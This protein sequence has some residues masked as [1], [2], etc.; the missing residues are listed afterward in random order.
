MENGLLF[1]LPELEETPAEKAPEKIIWVSGAEL[2]EYLCVSEP[3]ITK[4]KNTGFL[5]V[6]DKGKY[7]LKECVKSYIAK[8]VRTM[9]KKT[10]KAEEEDLDR[11]EQLWDIE[12]KKT[13]NKGWREQ[14]ATDLIS[15]VLRKL[16][17]STKNFAASLT[18]DSKEASLIMTIM[19]QIQ[20][21]DPKDVFYQKEGLDDSENA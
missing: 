7:D 18:Q 3:A 11:V 12:N 19:Q 5:V 15:I 6:N 10:E 17:A 14:Y 13:K 2:A 1:E 21:I 20:E 9:Q 8:K 16:Y 4:M